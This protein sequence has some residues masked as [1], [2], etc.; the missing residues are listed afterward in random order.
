[1]GRSRVSNKKKITADGTFDSGVEYERFLELRA[2]ENSKQISKLERQVKFVLIPK[3]DGERECT[4]KCDFAYSDKSGNYVVE[5][6]KSKYTRKFPEWP[7][8][9]KLMLFIHGIKVQ[10]VIY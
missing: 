4:Y 10:E 6:V 1:V 5:D 3:Q 9:R 2:L 8:K 7:I